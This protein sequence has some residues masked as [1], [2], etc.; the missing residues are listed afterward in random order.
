[1]MVIKNQILRG[2]TQERC[3]HHKWRG[4]IHQSSILKALDH[5]QIHKAEN[6]AKRKHKSVDTKE[7]KKKINKK[8]SSLKPSIK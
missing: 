1:M 4:T 8:A 2:E 3:F 6:N 5:Y 7:Y